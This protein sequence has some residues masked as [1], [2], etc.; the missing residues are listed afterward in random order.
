MSNF[1]I[2]FITYYMVFFKDKT[3]TYYLYELRVGLYFIH[4]EYLNL[5]GVYEFPTLQRN[6]EHLHSTKI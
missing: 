2:W 5:N 6:D 3:I 4:H 1:D